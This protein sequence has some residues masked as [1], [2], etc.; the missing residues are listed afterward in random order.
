[1]KKSAVGLFS[2][3]FVLCSVVLVISS[4]SKASGTLQARY[5]TQK[6]VPH[7]LLVKF[8]EY[9]VGDTGQNKWLIQN[10][11]N[12]VQGKIKTYL[13]KEIYVSNWEPSLISHRSFIDDPYLFHIKV[14]DAIDLDYAIS[15][16][17]SS[18]YIEYAEKNAIA[19]VDSTLPDDPRFVDQWALDKIQAPEAW[20]IFTGNPELVVAVL[21]TGIDINHEDL[22]GVLWTNPN[23]IEGDEIDND[24]NNYEDDIHGW[25]FVDNGANGNNN[26]IHDDQHLYLDYLSGECREGAPYHGTHMSGT[27]GA[28]GNNNKGISG[29]CWNVKIMPVKVA[30][31]CG[32]ASTSAIIHGIDYATDNGAFLLNICFSFGA[33]P[34]QSMLSAVART[35]KK[36]KLL[37]A[38]AGPGGAS[39]AKDVDHSSNS[40]VYPACFTFNNII[41]VLNTTSQ[42]GLASGSSWGKDS[43]DLG[44]P[45]EM[46]LSTRPI[47]DYQYASGTSPATA[48][49]SGVAALALGR[50]PGLTSGKL[51]DMILNGVDK[52]DDLKN[53]CVKEGRLNA[54]KVLN[55]IGGITTPNPPTSL[56]ACCTSWTTIRLLFQD[57]SDN[58]QGFEVQRK[59]NYQTV[60]IHD[61]CADANS[62]SMASFQDMTINPELQRTYTYR[63]RATNGAGASAF[64]NTASASIPYTLPET[65]TD[66]QGQS[67][68]LDQMVNINWSDIAVNELHYFVERRISG[69]GEWDVIV[70]LDANID[71]YN[72][73]TAHAG[74][75]YDY[76]VRASNPLGYSG[77]SNIVTIEVINW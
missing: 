68:T 57:N 59:D 51:R 23:E 19:H 18:P 24:L 10:V 58:E 75:T 70:T 53:K 76:R 32:L 1:M 36:S 54:Y 9:P 21:D 22:Q 50:C 31:P 35:L 26:D 11:I 67:P 33:P 3:L 39:P 52:S 45:G 17:Q 69:Y 20:D 25:N 46:I 29:V 40:K 63:V 73:P 13:N 60:F 38:S 30:N 72:D 74:N 66:L 12:S 7:E 6:Y 55:A 5:D 37:M 41:G 27:I 8:K 77:Y 42:D 4:H 64:S 62:T 44:A 65:P 43:I 14:P 16:L 2:A 48:Y 71:F 49:V 47:D 56:S 61:N 15:I 28:V 34:S